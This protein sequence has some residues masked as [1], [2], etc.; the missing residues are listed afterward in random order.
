MHNNK[1]VSGLVLAALLVTV[2]G[3]LNAQTAS[4]P[5]AGDYEGTIRPLQAT[6]RPLHLILHLRQSTGT[7]LTG[8]IDSIDQDVFGV[9]CADITESGMKFSFTVPDA[10]ESYQGEIS[11][12][13]NILTGTWTFGGSGPLVFSRK[14]GTETNYTG[15]LGTIQLTLHLRRS[16]GAGTTGTIDIDQT[17]LVFKCADIAESGMKLSFT[18]PEEDLRYQGDVS[19]DGNTITGMWNRKDSHPLVLARRP[20]TDAAS[21]KNDTKSGNYVHS[22]WVHF[23]PNGKLVYRTTSKG[24]R[25]P[26][27][28][29][30]GYRGGGIAL[31]QAPTRVTVSPSG[32]DDDTPALQAAIDK[33]ASLP[34]GP[35][36]IRGAVVLTSG[37]FNLAGTLRIKASGVVIRGAGSEGPEAS[38]LQMTGAPH[39]AMEIEGEYHKKALAPATYL[40]DTY[41]PAGST[42]IHV[43]DAAN[44][45]AGGTLE[46]TRPVTPEWI[47]FMGMDHLVRD[48]EPE[49]WLGGDIRILRNVE[50]VTGNAVRL[51]VPL[52]DSFDSRFYGA[53]GATLT[54][55]EITGQIEETGVEDLRIVAPNRSIDYHQD[56]HYDGIVMDNVVDSWLRGLAFKDTTNSVFIGYKA[57]RLTLERVDVQQQDT[58][59][60]HAQPFDFALDGSQI[61]LDRCSGAGNHVT[62]AAVKGR[63]EGPVVVL[64]CRFNGDGQ[65]EGHQR[66]STGLL[67]DNCA[68]PDGRINLRNRGELGSGHG[69]ANGWSVLW[70]NEAEVFVVQNPPGDLNWSIG[71]VGDHISQPMPVREDQLEG[72]PLPGGEV[73]SM[74]RHVE[75]VS[76]YLEQLRE[77]LGPAAVAA[78]GYP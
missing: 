60:S 37:T 30:A 38:L 65:I 29:S 42:L 57:E 76:L 9:R 64:N 21:H 19:P 7:G 52:T 40:T 8:T 71:D 55:V 63:S 78:I 3:S 16:A 18:V 20:G 5:L 69:W 56:A 47:H 1:T 53:E 49:T 54:P 2:H 32:K 44:I 15:K 72:P 68:V 39:L 27:F 13:G 12:D 51:T 58:V 28:S 34:P 59:T 23:G 74:G 61:L 36:G 22:A 70:N 62:Y 67:V 17:A 66:W 43:A 48:G 14:A 46:L 41:V 4:P 50:S 45:R 35:H 73:E 33:V 11:P 10:Q 31:P 6:G 26:D 77:R 25:I 75:P 24:D